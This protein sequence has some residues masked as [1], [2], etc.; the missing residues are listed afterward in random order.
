M[1]K[2]ILYIFVESLLATDKADSNYILLEGTLCVDPV[3]R[4]TPLNRQ[5]TDTCIAVNRRYPK[6]SDYLPLLA[7]SRNAVYL[8]NCKVGDKIS[9][10]GRIQ[11]RI[12]E[13]MIEEGTYEERTAYEVSAFDVNKVDERSDKSE[14]S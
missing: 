11:S 13:K 14:N 5:I 1:R 12:Y 8:S 3:Y 2:K 4:I 7:W 10:V 6:A 9:V